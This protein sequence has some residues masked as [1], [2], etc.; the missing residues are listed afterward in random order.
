MVLSITTTTVSTVTSTAVFATSLGLIAVL[1][2]ISF[3]VARELASVTD[4]PR[5]QRFGR[6][7]N[8]AIIPLL[9]AFTAIV[10]AKVAEVL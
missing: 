7:L 6:G 2:L 3:L 5:L 1:T 9:M 8:V 10:A 4:A